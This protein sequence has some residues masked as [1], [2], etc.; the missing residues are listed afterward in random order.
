MSKPMSDWNQP[1]QVYSS[2][3][4]K[5]LAWCILLTVYNTLLIYPSI[6]YSGNVM[7]SANVPYGY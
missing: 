3:K 7:S 4:T 5:T 6:I 1:K 2:S